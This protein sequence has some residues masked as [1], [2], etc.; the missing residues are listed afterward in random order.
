MTDPV[1]LAGW[2]TQAGLA[3]MSEAQLLDGFCQRLVAGGLPLGRALAM[4]D[5]LH[6]IYEGRAFRWELQQAGITAETE[7][8][9]TGGTDQV[10]EQWRRSPFFHLYE[11]GGSRLRRRLVGADLTDFPVLRGAARRRAHRLSGLDPSFRRRRRHG[12]DGVRLF[13]VDLRRA[14][15]TSTRRRWHCWSSWCRSSRWRSSARSL[16]PHRRARWSRPISVAT[17]AGGCWAAASR[18][19][20]PTGSAPCCGSPTCAATPASPTRAPPE[21]II[22]LLNDYAEAI[23]SS[24]HE[25]GGD[26]LKLIGDGILAIF[27]ADDAAAAC[28]CALAAE[29]LRA[30]AGR[31]AERAPGGAQGCRRPR[32]I[33]ACMSARCSTAISAARTGSTSPWSGRRSTR[34][35]GS[36]RCAAR[37]TA[38]CCCPRR[39]PPPRREADRAR[40]VS[41][42]R[43]ALRGVG[44]PQE[45]FTLDRQAS[46][47]ISRQRVP[48]RRETRGCRLGL[49]A[50]SAPRRARSS[51]AG[52]SA[53]P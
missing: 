32:P 35:A 27:H 51:P 47:L 37:S 30:R 39:S 31:G 21:Q 36:P 38:T 24:V 53:S 50:G 18:A 8:G 17:P 12:R 4:V 40:L 52:R 5:T 29:A 14:G 13:I 20:S 45:L 16:G 41:V 26:V 49:T 7:Y 42:G 28:G 2:L 10:S 34:S 48:H 44:R 6:P 19:A 22:P 25:A 46:A 3:G 33:S 9:R 11:T 15:R 43:Y 23:I 1:A